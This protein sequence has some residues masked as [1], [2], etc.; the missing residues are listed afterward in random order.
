M[1]WLEVMLNRHAIHYRQSERKSRIQGRSGF[2]KQKSVLRP[3]HRRLGHFSPVGVEELVYLIGSPNGRQQSSDY[4]PR[5]R[6][7]VGQNRRFA[8]EKSKKEP[9]RHSKGQGDQNTATN[10]NRHG[11][12]PP[13]SRTRSFWSLHSYPLEN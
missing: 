3:R 8:P 7:L 1:E 10:A 4:Y 2:I 13:P 12:N 9:T 5:P 11:N 6:N